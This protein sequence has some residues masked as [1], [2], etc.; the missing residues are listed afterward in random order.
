MRTLL[1]LGVIVSMLVGSCLAI[2]DD[3]YREIDVKNGGTIRGTV[4]L[5]GTPP[6]PEVIPVSRDVSSC[7]KTKMLQSLVTGKNGGLKN[8]I[9]GLEGVKEGKPMPR[10]VQIEIDQLTCEYAPHILIV[11]RNA[12]MGIKNGDSLLHNVHAYDLTGESDPQVGPPTLFNIALPVKGMKIARPMSQAGLVRLLCDAGHP[13]MNAYVLVTEHPYFT[14]TDE[15]GNFTLDNV[16]PGTYNITAWH[17]GLAKVE[18][19]TKSYKP[20]SACHTARKVTVSAGATATA[21]FTFT[22]SKQGN[23]PQLELSVQ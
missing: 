5:K 20:G 3:V 2:A 16:P 11:P 22:L 10:D 15:N 1:A 21:D 8:V 13:W 17:E 4:V 12:S 14:I 18:E 9:V 6:P 23:S 7:G 19:T